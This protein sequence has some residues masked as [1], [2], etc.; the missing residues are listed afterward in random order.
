MSAD[1]REMVAQGAARLEG[2]AIEVAWD[3]EASAKGGD[4][5]LSV[6]DGAVQVSDGGV[7]GQG[8]VS[9]G[10]HEK[11]PTPGGPRCGVGQVYK[12]LR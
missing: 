9:F 8:D 2:V 3:T 4:G 10:V 11:T 5:C 1:V 7:S 12:Q 6:F